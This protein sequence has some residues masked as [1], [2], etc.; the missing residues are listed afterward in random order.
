MEYTGTQAN[1]TV[2][3]V[4]APA[5]EK[6]RVPRCVVEGLTMREFVKFVRAGLLL[7][8]PDRVDK[9]GGASKFSTVSDLI[10]EIK[11]LPDSEQVFWDGEENATMEVEIDIDVVVDPV[12]DENESTDSSDEEEY[13]TME[14]T[15]PACMWRE[16]TKDVEEHRRGTRKS[17]P[18]PVED[19]LMQQ[20]KTANCVL[21]DNMLQMC[22]DLEEKM[23]EKITTEESMVVKTPPLDGFANLG[24]ILRD[25]EPEIVD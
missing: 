5:K 2:P 9:D 11:A 23:A 25:M 15:M 18:K 13:F 20:G 14:A 22:K 17:E 8:K 6:E 19:N 1:D 4:D 16:G 7:E 21:S 10:R 24:G 3:A 12:V